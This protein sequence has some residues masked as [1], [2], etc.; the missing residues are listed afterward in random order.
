MISVAASGDDTSVRQKFTSLT[1]NEKRTVESIIPKEQETA[2][3]IPTQRGV[4]TE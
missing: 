1:M 2:F 3:S 4:N